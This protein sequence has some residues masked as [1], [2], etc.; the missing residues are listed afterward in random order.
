MQIKNLYSNENIKISKANN[1]INLVNNISRNNNTIFI[2][3]NKLINRNSNLYN[4]LDKNS[5][6]K[7]CSF[8]FFIR[9]MSNSFWRYTYY[10]CFRNWYY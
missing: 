2:N 10:Y 5:N 3:D 9:L 1:G 8:K 6:K 4:I 7:V